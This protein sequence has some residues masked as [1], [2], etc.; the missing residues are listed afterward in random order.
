MNHFYL[1]KPRGPVVKLTT[2]VASYC[3]DM[4]EISSLN[5]HDLPVFDAAEFSVFV[6]VQ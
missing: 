3:D 2:S 4:L 6:D 5:L 1:T